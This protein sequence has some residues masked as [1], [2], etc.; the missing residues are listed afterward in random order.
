M[1]L[2]NMPIKPIFFSESFA[3]AFKAFIIHPL[4]LFFSRD[5]PFKIASSP[6]RSAIFSCAVMNVSVFRL[7]SSEVKLQE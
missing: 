1:P 3:F 2:N 4:G 6:I 7:I 5:F